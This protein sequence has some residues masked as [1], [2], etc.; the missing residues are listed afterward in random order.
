MGLG[1]VVTHRFSVRLHN[2]ILMTFDDSIYVNNVLLGCS[3]CVL[4]VRDSGALACIIWV[5]D[6]L[7][8]LI[9]TVTQ[10]RCICKNAD[11]QLITVHALQR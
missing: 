3:F 9:F 1:A 6:I 10:W 8:I 11:C 4:Q 7:G 5:S 2:H